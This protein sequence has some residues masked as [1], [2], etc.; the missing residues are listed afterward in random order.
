MLLAEEVV[1]FSSPKHYSGRPMRPKDVDT[2]SLVS[3]SSRNKM[4]EITVK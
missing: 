4:V 3:S 1:S 2:T